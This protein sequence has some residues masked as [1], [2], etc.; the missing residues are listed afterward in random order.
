M[1]Y[2]SESPRR[3]VPARGRAVPVRGRG[4]S[5]LKARLL[6][7]SAVIAGVAATAAAVTLVPLAAVWILSGSLTA[8][9]TVDRDTSLDRRTFARIA[10]RTRFVEAALAFGETVPTGIAAGEP[11][12]DAAPAA[13]V[14]ALAPPPPAPVAVTPAVAAAERSPTAAPAPAAAPEPV[15][16]APDA[17]RVKT[18]RVVAAPVAAPA[19]APTTTH[20]AAPAS[21]APPPPLHPVPQARPPVVAKAA[22]AEQ[23]PQLASV[24]TTLVALPPREDDRPARK[25]FD[26]LLPGA[27]RAP[28]DPASDDITGSITAYNN[29][30]TPRERDGDHRTAV[31]DISGHT[32]YLPNGERLEAHS[33]LGSNFDNPASIRIRMR[34]VTPPNTYNLVLRESLFHG[35][36]AIRLRP[37]DGSEMFG[38]DGMLAHSYMLGPRGESNGCVSFRNY[39]KFLAAFRRGEVARMVVVTRLAGSPAAVARRAS[40][41]ARVASSKISVAR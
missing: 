36:A 26:R 31:Y 11:A 21:V 2:R 35:V 33:G 30:E 6:A 9:A 3:V 7:G 24:S 5:R 18:I 17:V 22:S 29:P 15:I 8:T 12:P 27:R 16:A 20:T 28:A 41:A 23:G 14:A 37:I 34:G 39:D 25:L 32:V 40:E 1:A 19:S 10:P 4:A 13:I 38:R